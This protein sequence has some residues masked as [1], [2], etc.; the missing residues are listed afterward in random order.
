M[1]HVATNMSLSSDANAV[2]DSVVEGDLNML[3]SAAATSSIKR[4][5]LTSSTKA[6]FWPTPDVNGIYLNATSW[7][8]IGRAHV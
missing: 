1:I 4:F 8:E 6:G 5:V 3:R 2:C 7:N